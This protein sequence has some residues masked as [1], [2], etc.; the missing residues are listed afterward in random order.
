MR[1]SN[2]AFPAQNKACVCI[3]SQLY[4]RRAL[5]TTSPLPLFNSL[6]HLAYLT[7]TSPRI[8]EIMTMDGGL[9]RLVRLLHDFCISPPPPENPSVFYGLAPANTRTTKPI[10]TLNPTSWDKH[11]S[12]RFSLA[13]QCVVNIGVRGTEPIRSRVVQAG[14][15]EVVGCILEAWLAHRQ[16]GFNGNG[17]IT[18]GVGGSGGRESREQRHARRLARQQMQQRHEQ[19]RNEQ[20][21][22][23]AR[24][25][26]RQ[27]S[28]METPATTTN[29]TG[30]PSIIQN[31]QENESE[32]ASATSSTTAS[33][34]TST[35]D[36]SGTLIA[37]QRRTN[38]HM[39]NETATYHN[40]LPHSHNNRHVHPPSSPSPAPSTDDDI[41]VDMSSSASAN[42]SDADRS[43]ASNNA[44]PERRSSTHHAHVPVRRRGSR[45][46]VTPAPTMNQMAMNNGAGDNAHIVLTDDMPAGMIPGLDINIGEVGVGVVMDANDDLAMGAP[47]GAPGA[48]GIGVGG[49]GVGMGD[50]S[51][52]EMSMSETEREER[53]T[54]SNS[55][56]NANARRATPALAMGER[57]RSEEAVP[58]T[59]ASAV[60]ATSQ[61]DDGL[62][63][64]GTGTIRGGR[65]DVPPDVTPRAVVVGLPPAPAPVASSSSASGE[66][67]EPI[68]RSGTL[69]GRP[70]PAQSLDDLLDLGVGG[71]QSSTTPLRTRGDTI[72]PSQPQ[73]QSAIASVNSNSPPLINL[74]ATPHPNQNMGRGIVRPSA[75]APPG[76]H[77]TYP[78]PTPSPYRDEDVLLG[79]QLLAYLSKYPHVRQ[80][81]YK[82]RDGF[83]PVTAG[84]PAQPGA[85]KKKGKERER[86][87][88][89][90]IAA[91][92]S[93]ST[94]TSAS[95]IA[96]TETPNE[97]QPQTKKQTNVFS[98]VERF[99]F[100]P[101]S[102]HSDEGRVPQEIQY[103]AGVIMRNA[104]R[105]DDSRGGIRQCA[106][107]L[108][109]RWETYPREFAKCRRCR[110]A[111]YC[112]KEC[113]STAW[114][115]GHRFWCSAKE[116]GVDEDLP[117]PSSSAGGQQQSALAITERRAE[118]MRETVR[119][120]RAE[121][122]GRREEVEVLAALMMAN[123]QGQNVNV[124]N[125]RIPPQF[126]LPPPPN[127]GRRRG[128]E[129]DILADPAMYAEYLRTTL[130]ARGQPT[131][132][133]GRRRAETVTGVQ[134]PAGGR[135][136]IIPPYVPS[137]G[138]VHHRPRADDVPPVPERNLARRGEQ[139]DE[140]MDV[141]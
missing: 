138:Q 60:I 78:Q 109:G 46:T 56:I 94:S 120:E 48:M 97:A 81:F 141:S 93:S 111:K 86:G 16:L 61:E 96:T 113:Q 90:P 126:P 4:D 22:E 75:P 49:T 119:R 39:R 64:V 134:G 19:Q 52:E 110:K 51:L 67:S 27:M 18:G 77:R 122:G 25:L 35:R 99:T 116:V 11:A 21:D 17:G 80:A 29:P 24:A 6:T 9:E 104:C 40:S 130:G 100:R 129:R 71:A 102:S 127:G 5:D 92:V 33:P 32:T 28:H 54:T 128:G 53:E 125:I 63:S 88:E 37:P 10:P 76:S 84:L 85:A 87:N 124:P 79:L 36:R 72:V 50:V 137:P 65:R 34:V 91:A 20:D 103:W 121:R 1:E 115:E 44:S 123:T 8:R 43:D 135:A 118:Q 57:S 13:F 108:C 59:S 2:F 133:E 101:S 106:N 117:P 15:L 68:S 47:P 139:G 30:D 89:V 82:K 136:M 38:T 62:L 41:D 14:T 42:T 58:S 95:A 3:T 55:N 114:S 73:T 74:N 132:G 12:Y 69:R 107:M 26:Q 131:E 66:T 140:S 31:D 83:H 105:K 45:L 70:G 7:S 23:L 112:G 98:L